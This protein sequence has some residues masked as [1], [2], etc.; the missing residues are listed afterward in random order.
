MAASVTRPLFPKSKC[1]A[2]GRLGQSQEQAQRGGLASA[3]EAQEPSDRP[4]VEAE[5]QILNGGRDVAIALDETL[6]THHRDVGKGGDGSGRSLQEGLGADLHGEACS[7]RR[8]PR[9]GNPGL[10][11]V[12]S[13]EPRDLSTQVCRMLSSLEAK[14]IEVGLFPGDSTGG[15]RLIQ[16][17]TCMANPHRRQRLVEFGGTRG[18]LQSPRFDGRHPA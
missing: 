14:Q 7:P 10:R 4:R 15:H 11:L 16:H 1:S 8:P 5:R 18:S 12:R 9:P 17:G 6:D 2:G 3:I 13:N